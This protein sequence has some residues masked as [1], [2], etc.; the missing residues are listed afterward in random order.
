MKCTSEAKR[1][2][3]LHG[4][5]IYHNWQKCV[6]NFQYHLTFEFCRINSRYTLFRKELPF[7]QSIFISQI[8]DWFKI[9]KGTIWYLPFIHLKLIEVKY[10][11]SSPDTD[12]LI[13]FSM[14]PT[15]KNPK[16]IPSTLN[17]RIIQFKTAYTNDQHLEGYKGEIYPSQDKD[18]TLIQKLPSWDNSKPHR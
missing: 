11:F 3:L 4:K 15:D 18:F 17:N 12:K 6:G 16:C 10:H 8:I 1:F 2:H 9:T 5:V 7:G 14:S 13:S